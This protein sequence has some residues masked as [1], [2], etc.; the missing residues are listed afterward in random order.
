[1]KGVKKVIVIKGIF[2]ASLFLIFKCPLAIFKEGY[3][4]EAFELDAM[5]RSAESYEEAVALITELV[6]D[7]VL[8]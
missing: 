2:D 1:M 4:K 8:N 5:I 7:E 3:M 6:R